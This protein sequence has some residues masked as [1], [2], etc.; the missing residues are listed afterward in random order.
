MVSAKFD[1]FEA[2]AVSIQTYH[3][4][5]AQALE[6]AETHIRLEFADA[7]LHNH[8]LQ[9][10]SSTKISTNSLLYLKYFRYLW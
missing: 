2:E 10:Q 6:H 1:A 7:Q 5:R 4:K 8:F 3:L 9:R